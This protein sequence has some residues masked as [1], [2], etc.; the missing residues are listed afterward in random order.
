MKTCCST[1]VC[2]VF[3]LALFGFKCSTLFG[4]VA[5]EG[6]TAQDRFTVESD[7]VNEESPNGGAGKIVMPSSCWD[8]TVDYEV[9]VKNIG[10]YFVFFPQEGT[11]GG[12]LFVDADTG[13][14]GEYTLTP[15]GEGKT[16]LDGAY[17]VD[18]KGN[19]ILSPVGIPG[20]WLE[21]T[22]VSILAKGGLGATFVNG[23]VDPNVGNTKP[24]RVTFTKVN[25]QS[26]PAGIAPISH[27]FN[28]T[29]ADVIINGQEFS[30]A[31][32]QLN[33]KITFTKKSFRAIK[34][35]ET[36]SIDIDLSWEMPHPICAKF[37]DNETGSVTFSLRPQPAD[38][39]NV[40]EYLGE[41]KAYHRED[42]INCVFPDGSTCTGNAVCTVGIGV[43]GRVPNPVSLGCGAGS[44]IVDVAEV[45]DC[46]ITGCPMNTFGNFPIMFSL[47]FPYRNNA[48]VELPA[49]SGGVRFKLHLK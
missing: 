49:Y 46:G 13:A 31:E 2:F 38:P 42:W 15:S 39:N 48:V 35:K 29:G 12:H 7:L 8:V 3:V 10:D 41:G 30:N 34:C 22:I 25:G 32:I 36:G 33:L 28:Y 6:L 27:Q 47:E 18:S 24:S 19:I 1:L 40:C 17:T 21:D 9:T 43:V 16:L 45:F 20:A 37:S 4:M 44:L 23:G 26:L 14:G 5:D 11:T